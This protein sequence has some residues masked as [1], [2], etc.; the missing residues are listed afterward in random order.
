MHSG[1]KED[2]PI[3]FAKLWGQLDT[4]PFHCYVTSLPSTLGRASAATESA[5]KEGFINLGRS[6][7]LSREHATISWIP[8]QKTYQITCL[9]KNGMVVAGKYHAKGG[10]ER[11]ESRTPIKLGPASMYFLLPERAAPVAPPPEPIPVPASNELAVVPVAA[12][13]NVLAQG[14]GHPRTPSS[15]V[16]VVAAVASTPSASP[17]FDVMVLGAFRSPALA[18]AAAGE[19]LSSGD[20]VNWV[21][22]NFPEWNEEGPKMRSLAVGIQEVLSTSFIQTAGDRWKEG[23]ASVDAGTRRSRPPAAEV[24]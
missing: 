8:A 4:S 21:M 19:G 20:V 14:M 16:K 5:S 10:V 23:A 1:E 9:S 24:M 18:A 13:P 17:A 22:Q 15:N 3:A 12:S 7:A 2:E 11:L 6:K